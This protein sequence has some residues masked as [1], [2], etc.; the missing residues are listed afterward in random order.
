MV[1]PI[2]SSS[3][4]C[5]NFVLS[6]F[7]SA[8]KFSVVS[9]V[10]SIFVVVDVSSSLG[11]YRIEENAT[12]KIKHEKHKTKKNPNPNP[13]PDPK[14]NRCSSS[15]P[16]LV[17]KWFF[18]LEKFNTKDI[19][20]IKHFYTTRWYNT[21]TTLKYSTKLIQQV[22][23][24]HWY[25]KKISGRFSHQERPVLLSVK[26]QKRKSEN[27]TIPYDTENTTRIQHLYSIRIQHGIYTTKK[28]KS[29]VGVL[30]TVLEALRSYL[31]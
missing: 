16:L 19:T 22:Y 2:S 14:P 15:F 11:I 1:K 3:S 13:K 30:G 24:R 10:T 23:T 7:F 4:V 27:N 9:C 8:L 17:I 31:H 26:K 5:Y 20:H 21:Y 6:S 18:S 12:R 28:I 29:K 25:I